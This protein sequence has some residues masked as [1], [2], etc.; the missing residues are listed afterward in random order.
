M[1]SVAALFIVALGCA[2]AEATPITYT[3]TGIGTG[4]IGATPFTNAAIT[5]VAKGNTA[6]IV[7][8]TF[9]D[10]PFPIYANP[11]SS[12]TVTIGGV[13]TATITDP[14]GIWSI[15]QPIPDFNDQAGI[16]FGRIDAPPVLDSFTGIGFAISNSLTGYALGPIALLNLQ[17]SIEFPQL[18]STPNH[19][20]CLHTSLGLLR[21]TS[22]EDLAPA[23]FKA[24]LDPV[25]T[26]EPTSLLL[27]GSGAVG[28]IGRS[29]SR[30]RRSD[31]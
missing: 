1:T 29:R 3:M 13:G 10:V 19:D 20:P 28:L 18:C 2:A 26:P 31:K 16:I 5:L 14:S 7:P 21:F 30:K 24:T 22:S 23:T 6:N 15:P 25:A 17:G 11:F 27:L 8:L 4:Q 9:S 12:F